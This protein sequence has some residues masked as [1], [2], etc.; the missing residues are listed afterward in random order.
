MKKCPIYS[1][2]FWCLLSVFKLNLEFTNK[3][4]SQTKSL[5]L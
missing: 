5:A 3:K 4:K 1:R 2:A